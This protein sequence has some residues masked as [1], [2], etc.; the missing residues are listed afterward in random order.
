MHRF[1]TDRNIDDILVI[2]GNVEASKIVLSQFY[3]TNPGNSKNVEAWGCRLEDW[4][5]RA[6]NKN[7]ID[8]GVIDEMLCT[9]FSSS[10]CSE[11]QDISCHKFDMIKSFG[12]LRI[13]MCKIETECKGQHK[14]SKIRILNQSVK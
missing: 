4:L 2:Y 1:G 7:N 6:N 9:K 12:K 3:N 11:V 10:L 5:D 13:E 14:P 8:A